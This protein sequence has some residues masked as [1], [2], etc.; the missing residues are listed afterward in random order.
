MKLEINHM[1]ESETANPSF[2][3]LRFCEYIAHELANPLN[4]M[5]LSVDLLARY[6][7]A[8]PCA[9]DQAGDLLKILRNEINRLAVLLKELHGSGVLL[10]IDPHPTTLSAEISDLLTLESAHYEQRR[11][12]INLDVPVDLP[13][14]MADRNKLRQVLLNLCKNAVEAMPDGGTLTIRGYARETWLC[15]DI[16]DT[17]NGIPA[18]MAVFEPAITDK[19]QGSGLGLAIVHEI[20]QQHEGTVSYTTQS[21]MGTTF[22]LKFPIPT[23]SPAN[24]EEKPQ[25]GRQDC[26]R[27]SQDGEYRWDSDSSRPRPS[28]SGRSLGSI[29][30]LI[31]IT[32]RQRADHALQTKDAKSPMEIASSY[33]ATLRLLGTSLLARAAAQ[34]VDQALFSTAIEYG[35]KGIK[36]PPKLF[37]SNLRRSGRFA[38]FNGRLTSSQKSP[39]PRSSSSRKS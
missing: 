30:P 10:D 27:R 34:G 21:G 13:P 35:L 18:G 36:A 1:Q 16:A 20:V 19:P 14:M 22:H 11:V 33:S 12:R 25:A 23:A 17:G 5:L 29:A 2:S 39:N 15:L 9:T 26:R 6:S 7:Q 4:G 37:A 38:W 8:T 28:D 32:D 24:G 3:P 31:D